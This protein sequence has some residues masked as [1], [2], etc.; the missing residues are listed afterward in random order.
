MA[1]QKKRPAAGE[2][3]FEDWDHALDEWD[4]NFNSL[5][6]EP[7]PVTPALSAVSPL[8]EPEST[9]APGVFDMRYGS[10]VR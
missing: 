5:V 2:K 10:P 1:D 7:A 6:D 3:G 4:A 8:I 9:V